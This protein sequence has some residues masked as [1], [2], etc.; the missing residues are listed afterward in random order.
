[1]VASQLYVLEVTRHHAYTYAIFAHLYRNCTT[2]P[3]L[4]LSDDC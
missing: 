4:S 1:M 3:K 2:D